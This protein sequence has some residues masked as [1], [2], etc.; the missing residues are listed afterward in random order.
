[1]ST[2]VHEVGQEPGALPLLSHA[3]LETWKRRNGRLLTFEGYQQA[4]GIRGAI[5]KTAD[6][7]YQYQL[8]N[9]QQTIARKIFISLT[10]LGEGTQD[11]RR[12]APLSELFYPPKQISAI[13]KVLRLLTNAR[14]VIVGEKTAEVAHEALIR[15]WPAMRRWLDEDREGLRIH[16]QL[17]ED[18][19]LWEELDCDV[20]ALY[21][22]ARLSH[23]LEWAATHTREMTSQERRFMAESRELEEREI[24]ERE[25]QQ[26]RELET[27][28]QLAQS[29]RQRA[30]EQAEATRRQGA[31]ARI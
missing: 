7:V 26:Q 16:R 8:N 10:E 4:G 24:R 28:Q 18:V 9:E 23:A 31:T 5:A 1:M 19:A 3:L 30:E 29:E 2:I 13:K 25:E 17:A 20:G 14:L 15:E 21:R 11:T 12:R 22:G 27:A 6:S